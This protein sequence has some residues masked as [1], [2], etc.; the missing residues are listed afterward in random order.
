MAANA[1]FTAMPYAQNASIAV[2]KTTDFK[3]FDASLPLIKGHAAGITDLTFSPFHDQLLASSSEDG[4]VKLW[5]IPDEGVTE[6][7]MQEDMAL[8]GHTRKVM[9]LRWHNSVE[10]LLASSAIDNTIRIWDVSQGKS[11]FTFEF[12][13]NATSLQ[14]NP[15]GNL[16]GAM[17]KGSTFS[18]FDPRN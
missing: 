8:V 7:I 17:I 11:A 18:L 12:K 3:R 15:K 1:K 9:V 10:N 5:M 14:W 13:N 16:L 4:K 2:W 6:H